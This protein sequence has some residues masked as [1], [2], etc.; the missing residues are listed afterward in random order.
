MVFLDELA[1]VDPEL[2]TRVR[3]LLGKNHRQIARALAGLAA[4]EA[5]GF[6]HHVD[7]PADEQATLL[8][9]GLRLLVREWRLDGCRW[10]LK[11]RGMKV[12]VAFTDML[13][14]GRR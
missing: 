5:A 10:D 14:R 4:E 12:V 13:T 9:G 7:E 3:E 11:D 2:K 8:L 6:S 1:D